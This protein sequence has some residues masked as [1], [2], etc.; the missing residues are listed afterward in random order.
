MK[1]HVDVRC[2]EKYDPEKLK[3]SN[4]DY[5]TMVCEQT[6][7][8]LSRYKRILGSMPKIHFH[9]FLHWMIKH[10]NRYISLCYR[11]GRRPLHHSKVIALEN[12]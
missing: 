4:P 6:F 7:A 11:S 8:W 9:F 12:N 1:N 3:E 2:K 10:R 5:N